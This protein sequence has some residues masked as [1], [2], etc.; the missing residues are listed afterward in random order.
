MEHLYRQVITR[1]IK[2]TR[3]RVNRTYKS[4]VLMNMWR[5]ICKNEHVKMN[6]WRLI[7]EYC[8]EMRK[9]EYK[10]SSYLMI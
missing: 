5:L 4:Q 7:C 2:S 9:K 6:M 8:I 1:E 10:V 3:N